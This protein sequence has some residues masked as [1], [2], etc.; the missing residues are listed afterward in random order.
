MESAAGL[1]DNFFGVGADQPP[2]W[3]VQTSS[4]FVLWISESSG[5][6]LSVTEQL[7]VIGI[8]N[9]CLSRLNLNLC[10]VGVS[11]FSPSRL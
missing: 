10:I 7:L 6:D 5:I 2:D 11:Y 3:K 8:L 9:F 4:I 1:Q